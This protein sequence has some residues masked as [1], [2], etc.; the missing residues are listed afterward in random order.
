M[1]T[2]NDHHPHLRLFNYLALYKCTYNNNNRRVRYKQR[3]NFFK[4][5]FFPQLFHSNVFSN[6]VSVYKCH[7]N[8]L[9]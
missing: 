3:S 7:G 6:I 1:F 2:N 8:K 4:H 5:Y 9:R